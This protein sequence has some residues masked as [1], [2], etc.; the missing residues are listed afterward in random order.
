MPGAPGRWVSCCNG[1]RHQMWEWGAQ[2]PSKHPTF[3][4]WTCWHLKEGLK[5]V[6][7]HFLIWDGISWG[8]DDK[9]F[10]PFNSFNCLTYG[11]FSDHQLPASSPSRS[12]VKLTSTHT[13]THLASFV[14][15]CQNFWHDMPTFILETPKDSEFVTNRMIQTTGQDFKFQFTYSVIF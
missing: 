4:K 7:V 8:F 13:H 6:F 9:G 12:P 11:T 10:L 15:N 5:S 1:P 3:A 2:P 14:L